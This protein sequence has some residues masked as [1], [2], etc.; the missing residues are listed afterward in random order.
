MT[1]RQRDNNDKNNESPQERGG[2]N[3]NQ[4]IKV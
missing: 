1:D 4:L 2:K 3:P